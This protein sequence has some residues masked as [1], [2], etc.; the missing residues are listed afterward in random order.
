[1]T[2]TAPEHVIYVDSPVGRLTLA[3]CDDKLTHLLYGEHFA[4]TASD[5]V[6]LE[7]Q[8]QLEEYF[9]GTRREFCLPLAP[10]GTPFQCDVWQ[11]LRNIPYGETVSY[12]DIAR[13][14]GR[15]KA[16]RA[17]GQANHV[18]PIS[19]IIPCHRVV[20]STGKLTGYGGGLTIKQY[21]L[22]LESRVLSRE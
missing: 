6:L 22:A 20:G 17:V 10:K 9:R 13:A 8:K 1:M 5:A 2:R 11:A 3:S 15:E 19:I 21:L 16:F 7:T 14:V 12:G 4:A 18:N